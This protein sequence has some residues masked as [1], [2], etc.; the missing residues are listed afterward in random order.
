MIDFAGP[1]DIAAAA[2]WYSAVAGLLAGFA[3]LA[4]LLP[5]EHEA[6]DADT[7][8]AS[9]A[10]VIYTCSFF[11]LL[12]L[13]IGYA[14]LAGRTGDHTAS[15]VAA[16]EQMLNGV[17]FGLA[18]LLLLLGLHA[19][20]RTYG[21]NREVFAPART[22]I[23]AVTSV[24]APVLVLALQ[25]SNTV[26]LQR[27]RDGGGPVGLAEGVV[28]NLAIVGIGAAAIVFVAVA[29]NRLP[30]AATAPRVV[31][32]V[33]LGYTVAVTIWTSVAVPLL[34]VAVMTSAA[35]EHSLMG[36][37]AIGAVLFSMA[38]WAGR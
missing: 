15:A 38:S 31:A 23:M 2:G 7:T 8:Y 11:S 26:E 25:F 21:A 6:A 32:Q 12:I 9:N 22:V 4:I 29:R 13:S 1:F 19:V 27:Y 37:T 30:L 36:L 10:V 14:G 17:A 5:L 34:P 28:V 20:L 35:L 16:H 24:L 18:T 33:V 3:L